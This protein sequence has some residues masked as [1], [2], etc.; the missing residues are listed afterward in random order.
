MAQGRVPSPICVKHPLSY[1]FFS[2]LKNNKN[3]TWIFNFSATNHPIELNQTAFQSYSKTVHAPYSIIPKFNLPVSRFQKKLKLQN[4]ISWKFSQILKN[5]PTFVTALVS[6]LEIDAPV[7]SRSV[8]RAYRRS[9]VAE[10][11]AYGTLVV[12]SPG[13]HLAALVERGAKGIYC[14]IAEHTKE[15]ERER[16]RERDKKIHRFASSSVFSSF[17]FFFFLFVD[18]PTRPKRQCP[19]NRRVTG[20]APTQRNCNVSVVLYRYTYERDELR[21]LT[22][23]SFIWEFSHGLDLLFLS[24]LF[25]VFFFF[26]FIV[27]CRILSSFFLKDLWTFPDNCYKTYIYNDV[28]SSRRWRSSGAASRRATHW[29]HHLW[30]SPTSSPLLS[31]LSLSLSVSIF[32]RLCNKQ[33]TIRQHDRTLCAGNA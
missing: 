15:R 14:T 20:F 18:S 24:F 9:V 22:L 29:N 30:I 33:A 10:S 13:V 6:R 5:S 12:I 4:E 19:R 21:D 25:L 3:P 2:K 1:R 26:F 8:K 11:V 23:R 7:I 28:V 32:C 17:F 27:W 16:E 31:S